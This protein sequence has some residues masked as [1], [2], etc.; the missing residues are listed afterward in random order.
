MKVNNSIKINLAID[1]NHW[2][3]LAVRLK[4]SE[5]RWF[6]DQ[7]KCT[8]T[9]R[10]QKSI[11]PSNRQ[12][13][14][15]NIFSFN[16][17]NHRETYRPKIVWVRRCVISD[18]FRFLSEKLSPI[19]ACNA[20]TY[21]FWC[22]CRIIWNDV[23]RWECGKNWIFLLFCLV[24]RACAKMPLM[25]TSHETIA[26]LLMYGRNRRRWVSDLYFTLWNDMFAIQ[27]KYICSSNS[28]HMVK[29][30]QKN[31]RCKPCC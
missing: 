19:F 12:M 15:L 22:L 20:Y 6:G 25:L 26:L 5:C 11:I 7:M 16:G 4:A 30:V 29:L 13:D 3:W 21:I 8:T 1:W 31:L 17:K 14:S 23:H 24:W 18:I 9:D 27:V 10:W 2:K 28:N